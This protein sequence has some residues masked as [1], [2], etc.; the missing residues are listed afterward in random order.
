MNEAAA[1]KGENAEPEHRTGRRQAERREEA[2]RRM[3]EAAI[4]LISSK[5]LAGLTLNEVGEAA[6]YSRG[7]PTHYFGRK[8]DLLTGVACHLTHEFSKTL[9]QALHRGGAVGLK[10][11]LQCADCY[12]ESFVKHP[13]FMRALFITFAEASNHADIFPSVIE[14][15]RSSVKRFSDPIRFGQKTGEIRT[16][17]DPDMQGFLILCQLR[18]VMAQWF[19]DPGA[20]DM[21]RIRD[22]FRQSLERSLKA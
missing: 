5:G 12:L 2:E 10:A 11:L 22:A 17:L 20:I 16:D 18:G 3:L 15:S 8:D 1:N 21:G 4:H 19:V 9:E 13:S 14:L 7:L 6:G